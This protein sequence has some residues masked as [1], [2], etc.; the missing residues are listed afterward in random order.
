MTSALGAA[1]AS[2]RSMGPTASSTS[3]DTA[4]TSVLPR[5][6]ATIADDAALPAFVHA[7]DAAVATTSALLDRLT[8]GQ[9]HVV[10]ASLPPEVRTLLASSSL[11]REDRPTLTG[12]RAELFDRVGNDLGVAPASAELIVSAVFRALQQLLP[13]EV[14]EHVAQQLPHDLRHL[15]LSPAPAGTEDIAGD[16]D[17][18]RQVLDDIERSRA[19]PIRVTARDAFSSVMCLFEQ[20]LSG[21]DARDLLLGLPRALRPFVERCMLER[22]EQPTTFDLDELTANVAQDLGLDLAQAASVLAAVI[23]AVTRA[24]PQEE[25]DRVASQLPRDIRSLW[26]A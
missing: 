13:T 25:I 7:N 16:L 21:G 8:T 19:L 26:L 3:Y 22:R 12:G 2:A 14:I 18:L 6:L 4:S 9:A 1:D 15:W 20:R 10:L 23:A 24:L 11:G 5:F 17:L